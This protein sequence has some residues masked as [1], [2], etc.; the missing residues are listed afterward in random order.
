MVS[1]FLGKS[2][3]KVCR[4]NSSSPSTRVLVLCDQL[5]LCFGI[6]LIS[7]TKFFKGVGNSDPGYP[8]TVLLFSGLG[9]VE[10]VVVPIVLSF[11]TCALGYSFPW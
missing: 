1:L 11:K 5:A 6:S 3:S 4:E 8:F 7:A 9:S 2:E 10:L